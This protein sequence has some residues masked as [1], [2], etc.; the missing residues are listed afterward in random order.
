[1]LRDEKFRPQDST[2]FTSPTLF[3]S[4]DNEHL[5]ILSIVHYVWG[6]LCALLSCFLIFH[7]IFGLFITIALQFFGH[8][9]QAPPAF[10]GM[11]M[12][13]LAGCFMLLGWLFAGLTIS[14]GIC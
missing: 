11:F 1:M 6:G 10:M 5:R 2:F 12:S 3:L 13:A 8:G 7:F 9:P 4:I 14:S